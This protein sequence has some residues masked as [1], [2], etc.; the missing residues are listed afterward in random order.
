MAWKASGVVDQRRK[1][2]QEYE[3]GNWTMAELCRLYEISRE[4]G[5]KWIKRIRARGEQ[6][7]EAR[8]RA[9][10][11]PPNQAAANIEQQ[12][13]QLRRRHA[14][15]GPRKL[16]YVLGQKQPQVVWPAASTVGALLKR[17]GLT[18]A[19]RARRKTPP[20]TQPFQNAIEPN[21]LWCADF[22]GWFRTRDQQRID[23]LTISDAASRYLLRC[24][25]VEK[26]DTLRVRA[27]FEAAFREYGLPVAMRTDNGAPFA[28]RAI[29][30][31]SSL[32]IYW[33]KLGI[34]PELIVPGAFE[35]NGRPGRI[36]PPSH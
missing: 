9:P 12:V 7:L 4:S 32:S 1:F 2:V 25:A 36:H 29:A 24:Q 13:L 14:T 16:L 23:P 18:V 35:Q 11:S 30:G 33:M 17:E 10:P 28:S 19:R 3:S 31:L 20:Y 21:Q 34:I 5:Y 15:W 6:G 22:K 27:I 26:M 8:S